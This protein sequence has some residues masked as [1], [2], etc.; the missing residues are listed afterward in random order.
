MPISKFSGFEMETEETIREIFSE[1]KIWVS[2]VESLEI[3]PEHVR[4]IYSPVVQEIPGECVI[5]EILELFSVSL[6]GTA[7]TVDMKKDLCL[8]IE[9]GLNK[10]A[11]TGKLKVRPK[12]AV[13]I[14]RTVDRDEWEFHSWDI[15][16]R[17]IEEALPANGK[18]LKCVSCHESSNALV[19]AKCGECGA[20]MCER[21]IFECDTCKKEL[22][23]T[24]WSING[25]YCFGCHPQI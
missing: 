14:I 21:H 11:D 19:V 6:A 2:S 16:P 23:H 8:S 22:C 1:I 18:S 24:C 25:Q 7:R 15:P 20:K 12:K 13:I 3:G 9:A 5:F 4:P 10:F 17:E